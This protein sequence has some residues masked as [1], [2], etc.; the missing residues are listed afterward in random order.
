[1]QYPASRLRPAVPAIL[2]ALSLACASSAFAREP[3]PTRSLRDLPE[4]TDRLIVKYR[5]DSSLGLNAE[6]QLSVQAQ[7]AVQV[8]AN[9]QGV[10]IQHLRRMANGAQVFALNRAL[11]LSEANAMAASLRM[12]DASIEYAEPDRLHHPSL[13]TNDALL[14]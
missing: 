11:S 6:G 3:E 14:A 13:V 7:A 5:S 2:A 8:A 9:R 10:R 1:M 12:G 4:R